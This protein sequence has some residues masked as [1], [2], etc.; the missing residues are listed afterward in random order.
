MRR[1]PSERAYGWG[2]EKRLTSMTANAAS[3]TSSSEKNDGITHNLDVVLQRRALLR[4]ELR[5]GRVEDKPALTVRID[6]R[7]AGAYS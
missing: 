2:R 1:K 3:S 7:H 4:G 5:L 6:W